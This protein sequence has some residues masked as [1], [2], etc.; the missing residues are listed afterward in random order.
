MTPSS[1]G[2]AA[3]VYGMVQYNKVSNTRNA[4][5]DITTCLQNN[6]MKMDNKSVQRRLKQGVGISLVDVV[7]Q[8]LCTVRPL[9][10]DALVQVH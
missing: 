2:C 6:G 1:Y 7:H 3:H 5:Q 10:I 9:G 8:T 4:L